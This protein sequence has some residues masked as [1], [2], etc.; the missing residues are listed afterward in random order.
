MTAIYYRRNQTSELTCEQLDSNWDAVRERQ[1]HT[2]TQLASTI[3][4]LKSTVQGYD[5][6]LALQTC[7][8]NLTEQLEEL[9]DSIFGDGELATLITN[10]RNELLQDIAEVQ[11]D[12]NALKTR[13]TT[14]E[15]NIATINTTLTSLSSSISGLA[16]SKANINSPTFT[17]IPKAPIPVF[18]AEPTQIAT[19]GYVNTVT[20]PIGGTSFVDKVCT[21]G[22]VFEPGIYYFRNFTV[23]NTAI[24]SNP[25]IVNKAVKIYCSGTVTINGY[26]KVNP[27]AAGGESL[28]TSIFSIS[29]QASNIGVG[30]G[31]NRNEY[32][33]YLQMFG[34]GG[35]SGASVVYN[36]PSGEN[37]VLRAKGG[38]GGGSF[39]LQAAG[40]VNIAITGGILTEGENGNV[41]ST[42]AVE[43]VNTGAYTMI[44][45]EIGQGFASISGSG[46]GSGGLV[47]L[48]SVNSVTIRGTISVKGGNGGNALQAPPTGIDP[49][50]NAPAGGGSGGG[51]GFIVLVAP[52]VD[53][54]GATL[55]YSPGIRGTDLIAGYSGYT[56]PSV[57]IARGNDNPYGILPGGYGGG[58]GGNGGGGWIPTAK[59]S[60]T[61]TEFTNQLAS[62]GELIV[63]NQFPTLV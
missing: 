18:G 29:Q 63:I 25:V 32:S 55:N 37:P 21:P 40:T 35:M 24:I 15:N 10:L 13:V 19:V 62:A 5:F 17:G 12:L 30:L 45:G 39:I 33:W 59:I 44:P 1:N 56:K 6:I 28:W 36:N 53:N 23:P 58:Y 9:Q 8:T 3:S 14:T 57:N 11:T 48:S 26:I 43:D 51:G 4:N 42:K 46:G 41:G 22:E 61:T 7:C 50:L 60:S 38:D 27:V 16:S 52:V 2:G 20:S 54:I 31:N 49:A 34:S 47:Y